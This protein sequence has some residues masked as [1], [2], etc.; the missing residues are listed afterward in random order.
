MR[1]RPPEW[2][3]FSSRASNFEAKGRRLKV[4]EVAEMAALQPFHRRSADGLNCGKTTCR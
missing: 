3:A 4:N 2:P 1:S